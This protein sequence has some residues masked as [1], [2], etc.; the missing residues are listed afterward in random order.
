MDYYD[1]VELIQFNKK[2]KCYK[3]KSGDEVNFYYKDNYYYGIISEILINNKYKIY[4][5][6][7]TEIII[8]EDNIE[9]VKFNIGD[10]I[11]NKTNLYY[12]T[13]WGILNDK[14]YN[15]LYDKD[16]SKTK[17]DGTK[18]L[19]KLHENQLKLID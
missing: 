14:K 16:L 17:S 8:N 3:F 11:I 7:F 15:I 9:L 5:E 2:R 18:I 19:Y 1:D 13:I 6:K 10:K 4:N 12:G